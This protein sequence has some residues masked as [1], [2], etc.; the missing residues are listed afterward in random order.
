MTYAPASFKRAQYAYDRLSREDVFPP[1]PEPEV[2][3][4]AI[5]NECIV[6]PWV[7][8]VKYTDGKAETVATFEGDDRANDAAFYIKMKEGQR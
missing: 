6:R 3:F 4:E 7:E 1:E 8:V 2:T 5:R